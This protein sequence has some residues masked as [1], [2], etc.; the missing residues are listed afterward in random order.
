MRDIRTETLN[1]I[2]P[3][4]N[5]DEHNCLCIAALSRAF[6]NFGL[7]AWQSATVKKPAGDA[8]ETAVNGLTRLGST[9]QAPWRDL[10]HKFRTATVPPTNL[11]LERMLY[12]D[13]RRLSLSLFH[14]QP[15]RIE[16]S[17]T[18]L[19]PLQGE[20]RPLPARHSAP[21]PLYTRRPYTNRDGA[22]AQHLPVQQLGTRSRGLVLATAITPDS[23]TGDAMNTLYPSA[24]WL[25]GSS[26]ARLPPLVFL[27]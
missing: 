27:Q 10:S 19:A 24:R 4:M 26:L 20:C 21:S 23:A 6:N 16:L 25:W 8:L 14:R 12:I 11:T 1:F 9:R 2:P 18:Y 15:H 5:A 17:N 22:T 7:Q 13:R 3:Q